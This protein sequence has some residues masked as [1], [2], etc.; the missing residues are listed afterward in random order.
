MAVKRIVLDVETREGAE[1]HRFYSDLFDLK[2][3]MDLGWIVTLASE[4][5][6]QVQ[7]SIASEGGSG[8]PMP[9]ASSEVDNLEEV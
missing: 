2:T 7:I 1:V 8:T 9:D 4:Y 6:S 3:V 5:K